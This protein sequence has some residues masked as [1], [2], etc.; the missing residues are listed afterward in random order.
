MVTIRPAD[1]DDAGAL[2]E[3]ARRAYAR[4]V[5]RIGREPAPMTED[6]LSLVSAGR[7]WVAEQ[8]DVLVGLLVLELKADHLLLDNVAVR[9]DCQGAGIGA[10]L[11]AFTDNFAREHDLAEVRLYT[12]EAMT[13]NLAYY[14]RHG[15]VETHRA[16]DHGFHRV[17]FTKRL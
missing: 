9:P 14:P 10:Q 5:D 13:E 4:Y 15:F 6:Y 11:L 12:N 1:P 17:F 2:S 3:L 7:V 8:D 16:T